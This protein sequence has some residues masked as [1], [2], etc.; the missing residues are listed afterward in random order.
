MVQGI[1]ESL[2]EFT[3]EYVKTGDAAVG[4][5]L[6]GNYD[7]VLLD[8]RLP[9]LPGLLVLDGLRRIDKELP[10]VVVSAFGDKRTRE[11][12]LALGAS[13]YFV[14]PPDYRKLHRR[15]VELC[16]RREL[17]QIRPRIQTV[18]LEGQQAEQ[19]AMMRRLLKLREQAAR[20][21]ISTPPEILVE[22]E[23]IEQEM[24]GW[25]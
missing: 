24:A 15:M 16:A 6:K 4:R 20:M 21:G 7:L 10:V 1:I 18:Q 2:G 17:G 12:A 23:D 11:Q 22:I 13:D 25:N 3:V 14:K 19:A 5:F 9:G 8:L